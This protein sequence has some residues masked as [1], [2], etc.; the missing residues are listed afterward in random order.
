ME[1]KIEW[2][3]S[4]IS[5]LYEILIIILKKPVKKLLTKS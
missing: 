2:S 4:A 5:Q 1:I 3:E